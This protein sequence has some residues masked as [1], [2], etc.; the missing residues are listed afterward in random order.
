M[1]TS[2][3]I[4]GRQFAVS[5]EAH[6]VITKRLEALVAH[7]S[8]EQRDF[9]RSDME[10]RLAEY[11]ESHTQSGSPIGTEDVEAAFVAIGAGST[12]PDFDIT[13][14]DDEVDKVRQQK[15]QSKE[16][17]SPKEPATPKDEKKTQGETTGG[18]QTEQAQKGERKLYRYSA[19]SVIGGVCTGFARWMDINPV[20]LRLAL[21]V[22]T[23]LTCQVW[24]PLIYAVMWIIMPVG[25]VTVLPDG[26]TAPPQK[27]GCSGT[28][29]IVTLVVLGLVMLLFTVGF[30][31]FMLY[32]MEDLAIM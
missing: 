23:V 9:V 22:L 10:S 14:G 5:S 18:E 27:S 7:I 20:W 25:D 17:A 21:V 16:T 4:S 13:D 12:P 30:I 26:T 29:V 2:I 19:G 6:A 15:E 3:Y 11:F 32:A 8:G 1:E 28:A 24:I 31:A